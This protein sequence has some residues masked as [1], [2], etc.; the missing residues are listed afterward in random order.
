MTKHPNKELLESEWFKK[1]SEDELSARAILKNREGAPGTVCFLSQQMAEKYL[2]AYLVYKSKSFPK[3]HQLDRL[4]RLCKDV[5][6]DFED[7]KS[8]SEYLSAFYV[9][10]RYVG[11]YPEFTFF[12]AE[13]A[14]KEALN[15]K[16]FVLSKIHG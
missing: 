5:D 3:V 12:D 16:S 15:I 2:K 14:F 7:V 10:T 11:D 8:A 9:A 13:N 1:A 4:V 6:P